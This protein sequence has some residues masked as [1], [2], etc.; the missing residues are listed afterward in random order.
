[1]RRC[2]IRAPFCE[3]A[4]LRRQSPRRSDAAARGAHHISWQTNG[5]A[6][7]RPTWWYC[8]M[9]TST[10]AGKEPSTIAYTAVADITGGRNGHAVSHTPDL[11]LDLD[12]PVAMG[13]KGKGTNPEQL[14]AI[15]WGACFQGALGL[16]AKEMHIPAT[17]LVRSK[18]RSHISLGDEGE[19]FGIKA[20]ISRCICPMWTP[21]AVRLSSSAHRSS[22]LIPRRPRATSPRKSSWWIRSTRILSANGRVRWTTAPEYAS[23]R[24][25]ANPGEGLKHGRTDRVG[26]SVQHGGASSR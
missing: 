5:L 15:G 24:E 25:W 4:L 16:A 12:T 8:I 7:S 11:E 19:S 17:K 26:Q 23:G 3:R 2:S 10:Y 20:R 1:M 13:G 22:A 9:T 21:D 6:K 14:F 18:V